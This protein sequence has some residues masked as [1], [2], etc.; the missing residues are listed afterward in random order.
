MRVPGARSS[1]FAARRLPALLLLAV[2]ACSARTGTPGDGHSSQDTGPVIDVPPQPQT[3]TEHQTATFSVSAHGTAPLSYQWQ[4]GTNDLAGAT[5]ASYTTAATVTGDSGATF[6]VVVTNAAGK[7]TSDA[8][9]LTVNPASQGTAPSIT[10][11]PAAQTV[12]AGQTATFTVAATGTAPLA[13]Q[14]QRGT[15]AIPGATA[16][17]YTTAPTV[18]GDSGATFRVAVTNAAGS[19]TSAAA[20]LTVRSKP[21]IT[22]QP[23]SQTVTIGQAATFTVAATGTAPLTYQWRKNGAD[24]TGATSASYTTP[25]ATAGDSGATFQVV[26]TNAAGFAT[27]DPA[28]LTVNAAN[29]VTTYVYKDGV[30]NA[31][32]AA[33]VWSGCGTGN[34]NTSATFAG[35]TVASF[36]LTCSGAN[37]WDA[38]IFQ[39]GNGFS[40][41][42]Y[43]TLSFDIGSASS[44]GMAN[45]KVYLDGATASLGTVTAGALNHV[46]VKLAD[47][48]SPGTVN[49][50]GW[51]FTATGAGPKFFV[52]NVLLSGNKDISCQGDCAHL[53]FAVDVTKG[54]TS[55]SASPL[56]VS[57]YVYG[58]NPSE[59]DRGRKTRFGLFRS[60]GDNFPAYNWVADY[61]NHGA[62]YCYWAGL[63]SNA[64][65]PADAY[66]WLTGAAAKGIAGLVT[67]PVG[68]YLASRKVN[69]TW[70]ACDYTGNGS[71]NVN[72]IPFAPSDYFVANAPAKG[73]A[74]CPYPGPAGQTGSCA[75]DRAASTIYQDE[76]ANYMKHWYVDGQGATVFLELD[77]EPNYWP[78]THPELW[79]VAAHSDGLVKYDDIL[80]RNKAV[81]TAV[82]AA[83]PAAKIFGPVVAQDGIVYAHDYTRSDEFLDYYLPRMSGLL[84]VLDV[85][86]YNSSAQPKACLQNPRAFWDPAY[87]VPGNQ[88]GMD[89]I[90]G[91][92]ASWAHRQLL[93]RLLDKIAAAGMSPKPGLAITEYD[94]G[95]EGD[96]SGGVAEA[97]ALGLFGD[98]GVFAATAWLNARPK[99]NGALDR[100]RDY[101]GVAFDLFRN[102]DGNGAT[103]GDLS[104]KATAS[105]DHDTSV[106]AFAHAGDPSKLELVALN[107][108]TQALPVH[109]TLVTAASLQTATLFHLV[110]APAGVD[111]AVTPLGGAGPTVTCSA[112]NCVFDAVLEPLSGTTVVL[113]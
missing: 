12:N 4:R 9:R 48:G 61:S 105:N 45:L 52:N 96:I 71:V 90:A 79:T 85:H 14:W 113:R 51:W 74:L 101:A 98:Y 63:E 73:S 40:L 20:T 53:S 95:C 46:V 58:I 81:A 66:A 49:Q 103:V 18:A 88:D 44:A 1:I 69:Q 6:R 7:V 50:L 106:Y 60:G 8:A 83:W 89:Y 2:V 28:T 10:T 31:A 34:P 56:P 76:F 19:V 43:D 99:S 33:Q 100:T 92:I 30:V 72:G 54:P 86:Y 87:T 65:Y 107:K 55:R 41:A 97:E 39:D 21:T 3:V 77:N 84:D 82:K 108:T 27:S 37:G 13:Y 111:V 17:S 42:D 94:S 104:V 22:S 35:S 75:L 109:V 64:D 24:L 25:A 91:N 67:L 16:A 5:A 78:G 38:G 11:A 102:Y 80:S 23:A 36:D 112:G 59:E 26:V 70:P 29:I 32:F 62:N 68:P 15:T 93:P 110:K 47:L 57:P